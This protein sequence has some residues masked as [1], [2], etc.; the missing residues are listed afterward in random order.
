MF[1]A[2]WNTV[3]LNFIEFSRL[4]ELYPTGTMLVIRNPFITLYGAL[5]GKCP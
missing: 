3:K 5:T 4:T 1:D 2:K